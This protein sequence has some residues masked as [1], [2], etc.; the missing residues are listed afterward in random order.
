M[1]KLKYVLRSEK[2]HKTNKQLNDMQDQFLLKTTE[3]TLNKTNPQTPE[4]KNNPLTKTASHPDFFFFFKASS[5]PSMGLDFSK[6][7][8]SHLCS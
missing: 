4:T 3:K 6:E 7:L 8:S 1:A 5:T 2:L